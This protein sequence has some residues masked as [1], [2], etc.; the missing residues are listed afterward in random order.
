MAK[1][2]TYYV[3]QIRD[4]PSSD[5]ITNNDNNLYEPRDKWVNPHVYIY[6]RHY[7]RVEDND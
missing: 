5:I 7:T 1:W 4:T 6:I 3:Y 2:R